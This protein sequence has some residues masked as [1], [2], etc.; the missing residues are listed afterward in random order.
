MPGICLRLPEPL[1]AFA[2]GHTH[3]LSCPPASLCFSAPRTVRASLYRPGVRPVTGDWLVDCQ[4]HAG[5]IEIQR[6]GSRIC[7]SADGRGRGDSKSLVQTWRK[8]VGTFR[9]KPPEECPRRPPVC[10]RP[11]YSRCLL[12]GCGCWTLDTDPQSSFSHR[13]HGAED[14]VRRGPAGP[15]RRPQW[16]R[17]L[18]IA[19][20]STPT[21]S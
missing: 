21:R 6:C 20:P 8:E 12:A 11:S 15:G 19:L 10:P 18:L 13:P 17:Y 16:N 2:C 4:G 14:Q 3:L 1:T 5:A 9:S 7:S